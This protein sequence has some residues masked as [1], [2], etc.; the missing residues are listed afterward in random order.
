[1][2]TSPISRR[3]YSTHEREPSPA[4]SFLD[5]FP[6][7]AKPD[8]GRERSRVAEAYSTNYGHEDRDEGYESRRSGDMWANHTLKR[9]AVSQMEELQQQEA[10]K[11]LRHDDLSS[12]LQAPYSSYRYADAATQTELLETTAARLAQLREE[13]VAAKAQHEAQMAMSQ[14]I[15]EAEAARRRQTMAEVE[16]Q[17]KMAAWR[18]LSEASSNKESTTAGATMTGSA[19]A[20][21]SDRVRLQNSIGRTIV[22][23]SSAAKERVQSINKR[24]QVPEAPKAHH[25]MIQPVAKAE[26]STANHHATSPLPPTPKQSQNPSI[27]PNGTIKQTTVPDASKANGPV[28]RA[29]APDKSK[30]APSSP[31]RGRADSSGSHAVQIKTSGSP[32]GQERARAQA[33]IPWAPSSKLKHLTC[34]FWKNTVGCNKSA[35]DCTY[36]HFDTGMTASDPEHLKRYKRW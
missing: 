10:N 2:A 15:Y 34:Y 29:T 23:D 1:M 31:A 21:T 35:N 30:A 9:S 19:S 7:G 12:H 25:P 18:Q 28:K 22:E 16:Y 14:A 17:S 4:T 11:R 6:L 26:S 27:K 32:P 33:D 5:K 8:D 3:A 36:A 13:E 20:G 24:A